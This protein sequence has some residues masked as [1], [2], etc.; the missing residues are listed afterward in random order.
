M[1]FIF[2]LPLKIINTG[3]L[4]VTDILI[5]HLSLDM[6]TTKNTLLIRRNH[7]FWSEMHQNLSFKTYPRCPMSRHRTVSARHRTS[8]VYEGNQSHVIKNMAARMK[9]SS[10]LKYS[11]CC[12]SPPREIL[13]VRRYAYSMQLCR[14]LF[15]RIIHFLKLM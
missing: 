12:I 7:Y 14:K 4:L 6:S 9:F 10:P 15:I 8:L 1:A 11:F 13:Q 5:G 3:L 2:T